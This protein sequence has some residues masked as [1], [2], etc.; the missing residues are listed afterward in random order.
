LVADA[1][2]LAALLDA[3][4]ELAEELAPKSAYR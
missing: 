3:A 1:R 4:F 2:T